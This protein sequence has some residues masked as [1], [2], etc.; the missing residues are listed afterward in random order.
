MFMSHVNVRPCH[1]G[2]AR[3][4]VADGGDS[5][6]VWKVGENIVNRKSCTAENGCSSNL[7]VGQKAYNSSP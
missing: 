6:Q 1:H 7:G 3:P 4:R 2:M 5:L